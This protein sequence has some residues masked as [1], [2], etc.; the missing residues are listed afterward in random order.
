MIYRKSK[1]WV[2]LVL[3]RGVGRCHGG[4]LIRAICVEPRH[5]LSQNLISKP[6]SDLRWIFAFVDLCLRVGA[7]R[8]PSFYVGDLCKT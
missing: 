6:T 3:S 4:G 1:N 2:R 7:M 8:C 5:D